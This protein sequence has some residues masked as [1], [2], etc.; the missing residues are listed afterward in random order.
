MKFLPLMP[1]FASRDA[2]RL[3]VEVDQRLR[4]GVTPPSEPPPWLHASIM[5]GVRQQAEVRPVASRWRLVWAL[6]VVVVAILVGWLVFRPT[7]P[8]AGRLA[9]GDTP[10]PVLSEVA[11]QGAT[12]AVQPLDDELTNLTHD[13]KRTQEF[14]LASVP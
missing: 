1:W 12:L 7:A 3:D 4:A 14:L 13:L 2:K 6:P 9:S 5:N 10:A 8:Q 11:W